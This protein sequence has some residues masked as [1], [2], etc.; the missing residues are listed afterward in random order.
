M[1]YL[2]IIIAVITLISAGS[3]AYLYLNPGYLGHSISD[4]KLTSGEAKDFS[5]HLNKLRD[6][7]VNLKDTLARQSL[8]IQKLKDDNILDKARIVNLE[9]KLQ[10][11]PSE[12]KGGSSISNTQTS[13]EA[14]INPFELPYQ[15]FSPEL[16]KDPQFAKLFHDQVNEVIKEIQKEERDEQTKQFTTQLQQR[17]TKRIEEFAKAQNL[18]DFQQQELN[19]IVADRINKSMELFTKMRS[20]EM[21]QQEFRTQTNTLRSESNEKVKQILL[22]QQYE[23]YQKIE[24]QFNQGMGGGGGG[25][26][27]TTISRPRQRQE[28]TPT[29]P[30]QTR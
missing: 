29:N 18:N 15:S 30:P 13:S 21:E 4:E 25:M 23:E 14:K 20:Q 12:N 5:S 10:P 17:V 26:G 7:L 22:P 6:E 1:K 8:L 24:R 11:L 27:T 28:T 2:V 16:F 9:R 19:K 3:V